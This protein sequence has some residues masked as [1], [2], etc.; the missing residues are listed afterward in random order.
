[1]GAVV[2]IGN[3]TS[4][5]MLQHARVHRARAIISVC[6][7]DGTNAAV[8]VRSHELFQLRHTQELSCI[9]HII[10][11]QLC[12]LLRQRATESEREEDG[13]HLK[14]F[15][16]FESGAHA[17]LRD[18]PAFSA[19]S[20]GADQVHPL[21]IGLG[22][23]G[24]N[25]VLEAV[26][27]W[28][29]LHFNEAKRLAITVIDREAERK[30]ASLQ[31][32]Y[33]DLKEACD[34]QFLQMDV[35]DVEF[36]LAEFLY[37]SSQPDHRSRMSII[38]VCM[39]DDSLNLSSA[40]ILYHKLRSHPI[41]IVVRLLRSSGLAQLLKDGRNHAG[42]FAN[43][44]AFGLLDQTCTPEILLSENPSVTENRSCLQV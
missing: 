34:L 1:M 19:S 8:A 10:D 23:M 25:I 37:P 13:F 12:D 40:L 20:N 26:Q 11:P 2:W 6:G 7:D 18:Y 5:E 44:H 39:D 4:I 22:R 21:I 16:I 29:S 33:P 41:P 24:E 43:L 9:I 28:Q 17:L 38:Y 30:I 36:R 31:A 42:S 3:A 32:R 14:F 35:R 15:N 27:L